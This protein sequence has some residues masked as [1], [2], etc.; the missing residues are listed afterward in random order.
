MSRHIF[1]F[2]IESSGDSHQ[3]SETMYCPGAVYLV[4][5]LSGKDS[6]ACFAGSK[7]GNVESSDLIDLSPDPGPDFLHALL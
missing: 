1:S 2:A 3:T 5:L 4:L 6:V 7:W